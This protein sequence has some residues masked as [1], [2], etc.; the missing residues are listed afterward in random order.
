[1]FVKPNTCLGVGINYRSE[2]SDD[3]LAN[4][5]NFDFIEVS[6]ERFFNGTLNEKL[7]KIIKNIAVVLHGLSLSI[8]TY[9]KFVST[10][11]LEKLSNALSVSDCKW[12]SE[13]IAVTNVDNIELRALMP[14]VFNEENIDSISRKVKQLMAVT[15]KPFLLENITYYYSMPNCKL[16]ES[17]FI[18]EIINRSDCGLLLDIN[19]LYVNSINHGYDPYK[20]LNEIPLDRVVEV[21]LAGCDYMNNLLIDT[22]ASSIKKEVLSLFEYVCK[23]TG[24]S[25]VVIERDDKLESFVDLMS[26]IEVV[27]KI[28]YKYK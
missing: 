15:E 3:I 21:H 7:V 20:Y 14:I 1:M 5:N 11:Y 4:I 6:T 22:H 17:R 13:H 27:R 23:K 12:F 26:E 25:G 2:I 18:S 19:N 16:K 9:G 28:F 10:N 8:G 24:V